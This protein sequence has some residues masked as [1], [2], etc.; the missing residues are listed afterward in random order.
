MATLGAG[1]RLGPFEI[2]APIGAGGMGEVYRARDT[3]LDRT[4]AIKLLA[5]EF[6]NAPGRR[7]ERF[8]HEA[9]AIARITHPNICALHDVGEDGPALF[10]V[11]EYVE[12]TTLARRLEDGPLPLPLVLRVAIGVADAMDHAHRQGVV[13]RDLKPGNIML[14][15]DSVKLLDF[16]LAKLAPDGVPVADAATATGALTMRGEILGTL[17]YMAPEQLEG[18][19]VDARADI[20]SFGAMVH[21]MVTGQRAFA[22]S[23][24]ASLIGAI[25]HDDPP[26]MATLV[27]GTP[28]AL[29]RIISVCLSKDPR[30]RWSSAHDVLV[31]LEGLADGDVPELPTTHAPSRSRERIAWTTAAIAVLT[32]IGIGAVFVSQRTE[33][34]DAG[35]DRLSSVVPPQDASFVRGEAPRIS[36]DGRHVAFTAIDRTGTRGLYLRS[37]DSDTARLLLGTENGMQPFWSPDSRMLGFFAEGQLKT[38]A[39]AGGSPTAIARVPVPRG[40]AWSRDNLILFPPRPNASLVYVPASGGEPKSVPTPPKPGIPGF[41]S[42]LPD[43]RHYLFS[44]MNSET[45]LAEV[46]SLGSLDSP[47]TRR[48]VATTSSGMYASG[49]VLFR[50]NTTLLA[51][52]FDPDTLQLS[53]TPVAIAENVGFNPLTYQALF[54]SSDT[55]AIVYR[56]AL[57]GAE[58]VWFDRSGT[59]LS[60]AAPPA[61]YNSMCLT[62]DGSR[63]VYDLADPATGSINLWTLDLSTSMTMQLTFAGPVE[64]YPVCSPSGKDMV[65]AGLKPFVPNLF[66]QNI[67]APGQATLLLESPFAKIPTDWSRDGRQVIYSVLNGATGFDIEALALSGGQPQ[68]L[69]STRAEERNGKLSPN[70][71]WLAYSSNENGRFEV[72]VQTMPPNGSKWLV[73]RGG[74][75]QSQWSTDGSQLYYLAADRKLMVMPVRTD[76]VAFAPSAA[77]AMMDTS[78]TEWDVGG[79]HGLSYAVAPDGKRILISTSTDVGRPMT[80]LLNWT[81][82]L[83]PRSL[84]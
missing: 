9:R 15:R 78:V 25:L 77:T 58:L 45:R 7:V 3:R 30:S 20:F 64:F 82:A 38:V 63:I 32:A 8:R 39:I 4:V 56:D 55:G 53:G 12:G 61:E 75:I 28:R 14:T 31:Q 84:P 81:A 54:S 71:R 51:Q 66:R 69:V 70:G 16:G 33:P 79:T 52:P 37:R 43:G 48:L 59:R 26:P 36:P 76:G 40:A 24:Q 83:K 65:F 22:G 57:P 34:E 29:D 72:Y 74:G 49:Y 13:H 73:S 35:I 80:L 19:A 47:E 10:L 68:V 17:P 1:A 42:F 6:A 23:S 21:E 67:L 46:L 44:E 62:P 60:N 2:L 11:M 50:R 18:K 5:G 41:P 27:P